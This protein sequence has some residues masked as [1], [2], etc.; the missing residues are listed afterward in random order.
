MSPSINS[1]KIPFSLSSELFRADESKAQGEVEDLP[2]ELL[3]AGN[4]PHRQIWANHLK[5]QLQE[6]VK[7]QHPNSPQL[8]ILR[9]LGI[10]KKLAPDRALLQ[11][12]HGM[13]PKSSDQTLKPR[14]K[15]LLRNAVS[16]DMADLETRAIMEIIDGMSKDL[17]Y[18]THGILHELFIPP[19]NDSAVLLQLYRHCWSRF[20]ISCW[21]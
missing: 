13:L 2:L 20:V 4:S 11:T 7:R 8:Y 12:F 17:L 18:T 6:R 21:V 10:V 19:H 5:Q 3:A 9:L 15:E 14:I 16:A 1:G